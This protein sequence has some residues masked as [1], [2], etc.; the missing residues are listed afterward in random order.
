MVFTDVTKQI[1][2]DIVTKEYPKAIDTI[3]S[4]E[5]FAK[6]LPLVYA[7]KSQWVY[8]GEDCELYDRDWSTSIAY[9]EPIAKYPV[10]KY[11]IPN[12][13]VEPETIIDP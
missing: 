2:W 10:S 13:V 4:E 5:E 12:P 8:F 11:R 9:E 3:Y 7:K 1:T 6:I